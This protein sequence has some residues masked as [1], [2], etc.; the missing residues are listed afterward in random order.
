MIPN[1]EKTIASIAESLDT[2][3]GGVSMA[4]GVS[5]TERQW[6]KQERGSQSKGGPSPP[7]S[8]NSSTD[9]HPG[10]DGAPVNNNTKHPPY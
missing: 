7:T 2:S 8:T 4:G 3:E 6:V 9:T 10:S 5:K 1:A